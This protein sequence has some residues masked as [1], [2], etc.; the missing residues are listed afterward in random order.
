M[1]HQI[2]IDLFQRDNID[3]KPTYDDCGLMLYDGTQ[4]VHSGGSGCGCSAA[5]LCSYILREMENKILKKVLFCGTGALLSPTSS[6][7]GQSIPG[8][9]HL[10]CLEA[11]N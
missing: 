11:D 3:M 1:G 4:D 8:I 9:C 2:V 7:Q 10:V 6:N 5:V